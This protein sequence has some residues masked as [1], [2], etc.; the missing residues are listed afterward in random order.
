MLVILFYHFIL[1]FSFYASSIVLLSVGLFQIKIR[2]LMQRFTCTS[3][4]LY[5]GVVSRFAEQWNN[6]SSTQ[7]TNVAKSS[8]FREPNL[9]NTVACAACSKG[10]PYFVTCPSTRREI[11]PK[12]Y[13]LKL[14]KKTNVKNL[15][16]F[17]LAPYKGYAVVLQYEFFHKC[18]KLAT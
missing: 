14:L 1:L 16:G 15:A 12:I 7:W 3:S 5:T 13:D 17:Q 6:K 10:K 8:P 4:C 2:D 11:W 18:R 9:A